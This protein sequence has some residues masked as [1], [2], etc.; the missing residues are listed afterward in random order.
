VAVAG[1]L[2]GVGEPVLDRRRVGHVV[3]AHVLLFFD[4][5]ALVLEVGVGDLQRAEPV[6]LEPEAELE[7]LAREV[8]VVHRH[9]VRGAGVVVAADALHEG[10]VAHR[11][12][13][14]A[15][16]EHHVFEKVG[17]AGAALDLVARADVIKQGHVER[18]RGV[19]LDHEHAQAV[20]QVEVLDRHVEAGAGVLAGLLDGLSGGCGRG[21][22]GGRGGRSGGGVGEGRGREQ[23]EG[24]GNGAAARSSVR[25]VQR[26]HDGLLEGVAAATGAAKGA[27]A[28]SPGGRCRGAATLAQGALFARQVSGTPDLSQGWEGRSFKEGPALVDSACTQTL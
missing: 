4:R 28:E 26:H 1:A 8:V 22:G 20:G 10:E 27:K 5:L 24:D 6:R 3:H 25:G 11:R 18:R 7:V 12:H 9:V 13:V 21:L 2:P 15:A 17:E 14:L 19:V 16:L 23:A